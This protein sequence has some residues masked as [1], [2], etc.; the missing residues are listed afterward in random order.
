MSA[1]D[2][3]ANAARSL[4]MRLFGD[5]VRASPRAGE[6]VDDLGTGR[7]DAGVAART[8][9]PLAA[10]HEPRWQP[11]TTRPVPRARTVAA[12]P[13]DRV[14]RSGTTNTLTSGAWRRRAAQII[15]AESPDRL[16]FD[17]V[18]AE[19]DG[20]TAQGRAGCSRAR[21]GDHGPWSTSS[22]R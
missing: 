3:R 15:S 20:A 16:V 2:T 4:A 10:G 8:H 9:D 1:R 6:K 7:V 11:T 14:Q 18:G 5:V 22:W 13:E 21:H 19:Q 17:D 12:R